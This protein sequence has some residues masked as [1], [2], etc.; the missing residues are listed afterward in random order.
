M[1]QT[2]IFRPGFRLSLLDVV[3]LFCG[4]VAAWQVAQMDAGLAAVM[5]FTLG[6]F[7]LFC[8]IVRMARALE[9]VW[10]AVF[11]SLAITSLLFGLLTLNQVFLLCLLLTCVLVFVHSRSPSYHGVFW[12]KINPGLPDWWEKHG[13]G[14]K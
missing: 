6:H 3:V 10:A 5:L 9:L 7:F 2:R 12:K 8:N 1:T 11:L 13:S 14:W 4:A